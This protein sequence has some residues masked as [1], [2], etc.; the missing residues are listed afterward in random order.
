M[1]NIPLSGP[2]FNGNEMQYVKEC[3]DI[4][5]VSSTGKYVDLFEKKVAKYTESKYAIA[6]GN[7]TSASQVSLKFVV[8][9][10]RDEAIM[11]TLAFIA[12]IN[13]AAQNKVITQLNG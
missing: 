10:P 13:T 9:L 11:P 7:G 2:S 8:F 3:I 1:S 6:C 5:L 4:E 12:S